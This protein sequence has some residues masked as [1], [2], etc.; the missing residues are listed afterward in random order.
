MADQVPSVQLLGGRLP[1]GQYQLSWQMVTDPSRGEQYHPGDA[2][3]W[4][5]MV[6]QVGIPFYKLHSVCSQCLLVCEEVSGYCGFGAGK[7]CRDRP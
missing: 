2:V 3:H 1:P 4:V 7:A 6:A 5:A